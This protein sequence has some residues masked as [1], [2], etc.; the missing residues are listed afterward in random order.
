M[1]GVELSKGEASSYWAGWNPSPR[2]D[3]PDRW[4]VYDRRDRLG[5][6]EEKERWQADVLSLGAALGALV[7]DMERFSAKWSE[8]KP[9]LL[10]QWA[11]NEEEINALEQGYRC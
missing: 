3:A 1:T 4:R 2:R 11:L 6:L 7:G 10:V 8:A 9:H 5:L